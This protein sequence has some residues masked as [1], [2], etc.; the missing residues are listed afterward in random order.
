MWHEQV[1]R[2]GPVAIR[3]RVDRGNPVDM[4]ETEEAR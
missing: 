1:I 3:N 4:T 2:G